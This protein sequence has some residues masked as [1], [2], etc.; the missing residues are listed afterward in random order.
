MDLLKNKTILI[1]GASSGIGRD[2][3]MSLLQFDIQLLLVGRN[4][5]SLNQ[6]A[7][8]NNQRAKISVFQADFS[9]DNEIYSLLNYI[10][11][12]KIEP[13]IIIHCAGAFH[14]AS[15][16]DTSVDMMNESYN[17]NFKAPFLITKDL[18]DTLIKKK[19]QILFF[20]STASIY[21][22]ANVAA[23]ATIKSALKTFAEILHQE[24][25]PYGV[26][27]CSIYPGRV[28]TPMQEKV[29]ELEG[30]AY[31]PEKFIQA[32]T[33]SKTVID[34]LT[35]PDHVEISEIIIRPTT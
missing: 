28:A 17:V 22:K 9:R 7:E 25:Y 32:E 18:L 24:V 1:T 19:G 12:E 23:Y 20:N 10:H 4:M 14:L 21:P 34:L 29:C 11:T 27:V 5:D 35:L 2:I 13:D 3:S 33:I 26:K 16:Q 31:H 30:K 6:I 15:I 8:K